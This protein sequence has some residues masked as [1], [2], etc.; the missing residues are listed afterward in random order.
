MSNNEF[1]NPEAQPPKPAEPVPPTTGTATTVV[2]EEKKGGWERDVLEKL[3][4]FAVKEQRAR[5]RWSIF[6]KIAGLA[7]LVFVVWSAFNYTKSEAEPVGTHTALVEI[8]GTIEAEGRGSAAAVIPALDK[9]FAADDSLGVILKI[10][11]PGGSPVQAGMINDEIVRLRKQYPKKPLYVV[12]EEMCAS[13]GYY[14][15]AAADK[16]YVNKAS[17]VG[18]IGVLM[19]GFGFT[20]LMDKVGVERRLLT[21][22]ENKGFLD[23]F[24]AQ[25]P[26]QKEYAQQMLN[27]IHQQFIDVVRKG[28]GQ[29]LKET[30]ETFSGLFW[31]GSKAVEM[32]L[33]DG[34]GTVDSVARDVIKAE[35]LVDYTQTE[36]LPERVLKKF[37]VAV[38]SGV[39]KSMVGSNGLQLR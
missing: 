16:I 4:L 15:A 27:E 18:S 19:D 17:I 30:P 38:G 36:G 11:S 12:V 24:S 2:A 25:N 7:V 9:A 31:T 10:N 39:A 6:F 1:E 14:I 3:A 29:R 33:A 22:G 26:K 35:D 23:P 34:F 20:G 8:S 28:R 37:G 21:A 13:G 5:R 32:G